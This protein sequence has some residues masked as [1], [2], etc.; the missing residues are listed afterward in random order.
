MT[1]VSCFN[2]II[3]VMHLASIMNT[4]SLSMLTSCIAFQQNIGSCHYW[5]ANVIYCFVVQSGV[6]CVS[7]FDLVVTMRNVDLVAWLCVCV[8]K[9]ISFKSCRFCHLLLFRLLV[10]VLLHN[11]RLHYVNWRIFVRAIV[12]SLGIIPR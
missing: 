7:C 3:D 2:N 1:D 12:D 4:S 10:D 11:I 6:Q 5:L 9:Y 8:S